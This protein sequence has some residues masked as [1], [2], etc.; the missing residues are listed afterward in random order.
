[1]VEL[2]SWLYTDEAGTRRVYPTKLSAEAAKQLKDAARI[3]GTLE[4][5]DPLSSTVSVRA[6]KESTLESPADLLTVINRA[7][8]IASRLRELSKNS[9]PESR[10]LLAELS[11][12]LVN[13]RINLAMLK[14]RLSE[15]AKR[16]GE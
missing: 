10:T 12:E 5:K 15:L 11:N 14:V 8:L 2:W 9:E 13:A 7:S 6:S 16:I 3:E 1:M 4:A